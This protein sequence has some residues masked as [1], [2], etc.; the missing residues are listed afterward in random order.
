LLLV[1]AAIVGIT[2]GAAFVLTSSIFGAFILN[3][4][5]RANF[6]AIAGAIMNGGAAII[7]V[8]GGIIAAGNGGANWPY[9]YLLGLLIIPALIAFWILMPTKPE[10]VEAGDG[11]GFPGGPAPATKIPLK[12][13]LI[14][15]LGGLVTLGMAGFLLNV[16]LYIDTELGV[17][18]PAEA[19]VANSVFTILGV[20][21]G[22][23]FPFIIRFLKNLIAPIG[24]AI[25]A[26]GLFTMVFLNSSVVGIFLGA[27][28]CGLGFNIAM[29]FVM[30]HM[31]AISPPR[32][33]PMVMSVNMGLMNLLFFGVPTIL[34]QASKPF[35]GTIAVQLLIGA[36]VVSIGAAI[37][38]FLFVLW[39]APAPAAPPAAAEE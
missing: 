1:A 14:V 11:P 16:G 15:A 12:V 37:A 9:A 19:G 7:N 18:G 35:G 39:K 5:Q 24:Y 2:Q 30:G 33:I 8:V 20:V 36:I 34:G 32:Y 38:V 25:G 29:P 22:F 23:S 13:W 27:A 17:G 4:G 6:V 28:L 21:A 10:P 3:P 31:M 26:L